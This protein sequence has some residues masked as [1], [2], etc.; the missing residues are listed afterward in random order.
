[1]VLSSKLR[2]LFSRSE[3]QQRLRIIRSSEYMHAL[4]P[5]TKKSSFKP[6]Q[7]IF[8]CRR[9]C[10]VV[11]KAPLLA[12]MSE[13]KSNSSPVVSSSCEGNLGCG[14]K[15]E[16]YGLRRKSSSFQGVHVY[17]FSCCSNEKPQVEMLSHYSQLRAKMFLEF[18]KYICS[19]FQ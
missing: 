7:V 15:I 11:E 14:T 8:T 18:W 10:V 6:V 3:A 13:I 9:N 17:V 5:V 12:A 16:L 19:I 1:M 2:A 4:R